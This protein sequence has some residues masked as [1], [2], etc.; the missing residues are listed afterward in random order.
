M[1]KDVVKEVFGAVVK[2]KPYVNPRKIE[3]LAIKFSDP[4]FCEAFLRESSQQ[5][6]NCSFEDSLMGFV[7]MLLASSHPSAEE[8]I[9]NLILYGTKE[10]GIDLGFDGNRFE[11]TEI[12]GNLKA[13]YRK[14]ILCKPWL[15]ADLVDVNC[16]HWND[17]AVVGWIDEY[18]SE[19]RADILSTDAVIYA[20]MLHG[21]HKHIDNNRKKVKEWF[22]KQPDD[23]K[24]V[25]LKAYGA[26]RSFIKVFGQEGLDIITQYLPESQRIDLYA[27]TSLLFT[28]YPKSLALA[29]LR[30]LPPT[31]LV[32]FTD[33]EQFFH[34]PNRSAD[35]DPDDPRREFPLHGFQGDFVAQKLQVG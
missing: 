33:P 7:K 8:I 10:G 9:K 23:K 21:E 31:E 12:I 5:R 35:L 3:A 15:V 34:S 30:T 19:D 20:L 11:I 2:P 26:A 1:S 29:F 13:S 25:I 16:Y 28:D 4:A 27:N 24:A 6:K 14:E 22:D 18:E 32:K 17:E